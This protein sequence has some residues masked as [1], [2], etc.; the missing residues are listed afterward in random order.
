MIAV[1]RKFTKLRERRNKEGV[2]AELLLYDE[3][4]HSYCHEIVLPFVAIPL[5][6]EPFL[7]FN[8]TRKNGCSEDEEITTL[9]II[10]RNFVSS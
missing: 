2:A 3:N 10:S 6:F 5:R 1:G 8:Y 4:L 7:T 9:N